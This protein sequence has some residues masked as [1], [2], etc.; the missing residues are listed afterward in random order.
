MLPQYLAHAETALSRFARG[1]ALGRYRAHGKSWVIR[2]LERGKL[3]PSADQEVALLGTSIYS[4]IRLFRLQLSTREVA[5]W[6]GC[7][8][9]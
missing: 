5:S 1:F 8:V 6:S 7:L 9:E 3:T 4:P 2:Q